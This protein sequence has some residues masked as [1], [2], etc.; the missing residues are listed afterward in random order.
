MQLH[1]RVG[2]LGLIPLS[3]LQAGQEEELQEL[4]TLASTKV[5]A[6]EHPTEVICP[7]SRK[8]RFLTL[9][10][11]IFPGITPLFDRNGWCKTFSRVN[12]YQLHSE[13]AFSDEVNRNADLVQPEV[14]IPITTSLPKGSYQE[15]RIMSSLSIGYFHTTIYLGPH[16]APDCVDDVVRMIGNAHAPRIKGAEL[17]P[18][19]VAPEKSYGIAEVPF[20]DKVQELYQKATALIET[21]S[22]A[23]GMSPTDLNQLRTDASMNRNCAVRELSQKAYGESLAGLLLADEINF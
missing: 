4:I 2:G 23:I 16:Y 5:I 12:P 22:K 3:S 19:K 14:V 1:G 13:H 8:E 20:W 6:L 18:G 11:G 10:N 7:G 15:L 9:M 17:L 21:S